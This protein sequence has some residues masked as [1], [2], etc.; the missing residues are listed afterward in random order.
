MITVEESEPVPAEVMP[1][2]ATW[3]SG[4]YIDRANV[5]IL[6]IQARTKFEG[7]VKIAS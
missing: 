2:E 3:S 6:D 1:W 5:N 7:S 4:V